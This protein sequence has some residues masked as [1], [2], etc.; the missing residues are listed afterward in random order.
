MLHTGQTGPEKKTVNVVV[1][2]DERRAEPGGAPD[3]LEILEIKGE[4][5]RART[6]KAQGDNLGGRGTTTKAASDGC[7]A[8]TG[9]EKKK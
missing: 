3:S 8:T 5:N 9:P 7:P 4:Q 1:G 6:E 2:T